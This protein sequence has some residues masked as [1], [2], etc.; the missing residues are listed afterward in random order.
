MTVARTITRRVAA[1]FMPP[2]FEHSVTFPS[3][4]WT[5]THQTFVKSAETRAER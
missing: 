2:R 5:K 1:P 3:H 4:I